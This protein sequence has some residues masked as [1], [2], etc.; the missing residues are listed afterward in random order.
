MK[1]TKFIPAA[2]ALTLAT[3]VASATEITPVNT[4]YADYTITVPE[5]FT[6]E[7]EALTNTVS[8]VK[9]D[10]TFD[11]LSWTGTM[12]ATYKVASNMPN[13]V[14]YIKATCV[15][16]GGAVKAFNTDVND[17]KV[18]FANVAN[19]PAPAAISDVLAASPTG[20]SANAF[21]VAFTRDAV[22]TD[23]GVLSTPTMT[24][25]ELVYTITTPG[26][27]HIPFHFATESVA[28]TFTSL[29]Q[30][31]DYKATITITDVP[32]A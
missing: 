12:G 23:E 17:I 24:N 22:T 26:T 4:L 15:G 1:F 32:S 3:G 30:A 9:I 2:L 19:A 5:I 27:F 21:A 7:Q 18:A 29:D 10:D 31:G 6:I 28:N 14:F 20:A 13:K 16:S 11:R 25:Q 8:A